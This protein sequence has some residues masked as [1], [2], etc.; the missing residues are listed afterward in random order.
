MKPDEPQLAGYDLQRT[1]GVD[2]NG[3]WP[4]PAR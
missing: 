3:P 4:R 2:P 1:F